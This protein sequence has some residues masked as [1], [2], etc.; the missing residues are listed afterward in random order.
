MSEWMLN[1]TWFNTSSSPPS[2]R[3]L[4][5]ALCLS[6]LIECM[7]KALPPHLIVLLQ[8]KYSE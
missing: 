7:G 6:F 2:P 4:R 8:I 1:L 3:N 5:K